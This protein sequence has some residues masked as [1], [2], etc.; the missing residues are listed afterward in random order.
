MK[1]LSDGEVYPVRVPGSVLLTLQENNVIPDLFVNDNEKYGLEVM[2]EEFEFESVFDCDSAV[3]QAVRKELVFEGIDTLAD[4][5]L[6]DI[7]I[8][9][10]ENMHRTYRVDVTDCVKEKENRLRIHFYSPLKYI[11]QAYSECECDGSDDAMEGF[12]HLRKAH[13]MFGWD[14]GPRIPDAGLFRP[15]TLEGINRARIS[16]VRVHQEHIDGKV[17]LTLFI[18]EERTYA[19]KDDGGCDISYDVAL[20]DPEGTTVF[21][22]SYTH[23][24][25]IRV[26][27]P[28]LWWP[29]GLGEQNLYGLQITQSVCGVTT[30]VVTKRI[31]LRTLTVTRKK[32]EWG[33]SFSHCVNGVDVF[34]MGADYIPED[35]LLGRMNENRTRKL[36]EDCRAVGFNSIR[37]W[38][39]GFF[40]GDDFYDICDELGL[41]VWQ[42][43]MFACGVY[44]LTEEF[45]ENIHAEIRDNLKRIA[46]H[47]CLALICG[48]NEME[49][50]VKG[51]LWVKTHRQRA[52]YIKMY[53]YIFPK[54]VSEY[55]PDVVYWPSSPS[56]GGSFD[57]PNDENRGDVH[58]WSVWHDNKPFTEYRKHFF[59]YLSEFG[60]Q[61]LPSVKTLETVITEKEDFNLFSYNME[62]HQRNRSA[63][64][65]IMQ[66]MQATFKYPTDFETLIYASQLLSGEAI[67]YGVEHFRRNRGRCMGT[68]YWQL[69]DCWPVISWASI[70]YCGRWK[71]LHYFAKRFF[72][73]VLLS[74]E[75][76]STVSEGIEVNSEKTA[77]TPAIKLNVSNESMLDRK[78]EIEWE[79]RD[80]S[81]RE[82]ALSNGKVQTK[83]RFEAEVKALSAVWFPEVHLPGIDIYSD[84]V[85]YRAKE[86]GDTFSQGSVMFVPPKYFGFEDPHLS[87]TAVSDN[88]LKVSADSFAKNIEIINEDD[89]LVLSDNFFDMDPGERILEVVRGSVNGLKIRSVY[90]IR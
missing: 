3:F 88:K 14:W 6:N 49:M 20:T 63:N 23:G 46:H 76:T 57:E 48:N 10:A 25:C 86:K 51:G 61:S 54:W 17:D 82:I 81:G 58:Y 55:A 7:L 44:N 75:E 74:C 40:P 31:G 13:Y 24:D 80:A 41:M 47:A 43:L 2:E 85:S 18:D 1:R 73:P 5:Y 12:V 11:R 72:A 53:E 77:F 84:Y 78:L 89:D 70:D 16:G 60:F 36:L 62:K 27:E 35:N 83:G 15:V 79:L 65:K 9:K 34:A 59:R 30:D 90:D 32:D 52:D 56:S 26:D 21:S 71:A 50:F 33:E 66:Y 67:K 37:V 29:N 22:G 87:V 28:R 4:V 45:E 38:G 64:S 19:F 69:N 68:L 8:L 42:D 39:G